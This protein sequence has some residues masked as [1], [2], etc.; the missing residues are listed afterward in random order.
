MYYYSSSCGTVQWDEPPLGEPTWQP[1]TGENGGW[2]WLN[3]ATDEVLSERPPNLGGESTASQRWEMCWDVEFEAHYYASI[4]V[5]QWEAP[6]AAVAAD[7]WERHF[8][9]ATQA[10]FV[11][12]SRAAADRARAYIQI[13]QRDS[14]R[15]RRRAGTGPTAR[16]SR[17]GSRR[18]RRT[19][20]RGR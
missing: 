1:F 6:D 5:Q 16:V 12:R 11:A 3:L 4:D 19:V 13:S 7:I 18:S 2:Q 8:D 9:D 10:P 15:E 14:H 17:R 20:R